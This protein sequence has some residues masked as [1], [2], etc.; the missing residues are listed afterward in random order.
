MEA[1]GYASTQS[2][3]C[4]KG[5]QKITTKECCTMSVLKIASCT[6]HHPINKNLGKFFKHVMQGGRCSNVTKSASEKHSQKD[7]FLKER[8]KNVL[9]KTN[10]L[11]FN[12]AI[13]HL[14]ALLIITQKYLQRFKLYS[15]SLQ[16]HMSMQ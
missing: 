10:A 11:F 14:L 5:V 3:E 8:K 13:H 4:M 6:K 1:D 12:V 16:H 2:N 9:I 15:K 7:R